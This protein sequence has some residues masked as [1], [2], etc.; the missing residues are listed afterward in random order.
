MDDEEK[1]EGE[2][3]EKSETSGFKELVMK[4]REKGH[5]DEEIVNT[6]LKLADEGKVELE[7]KDDE[8]EDEKNYDEGLHAGE[9]KMSSWLGHKI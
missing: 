9:D 4:L 2:A 8:D 6:L 3:E 1:K 5:S 7:G